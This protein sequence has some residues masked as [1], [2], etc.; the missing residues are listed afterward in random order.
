MAISTDEAPAGM[1]DE[2]AEVTAVDEEKFRMGLLEVSAAKLAAR[3][4]RGNR[5]HREPGFDEHH[6][7]R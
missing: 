7:N 1:G 6:I 3:Y 4:V 2:F 5:Q